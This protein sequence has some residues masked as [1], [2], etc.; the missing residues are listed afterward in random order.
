MTNRQIRITMLYDK[1]GPTGKDIV[2]L[3]SSLI[4]I[5]LFIML[6]NASMRGF[7]RAVRIGEFEGE[8]ALRIPTSPPR[9]MVIIG[10]AFVVLQFLVNAGKSVYSIVNRI[11]GRMQA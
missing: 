7:L 10:S 6:I 5:V 8:G 1:M 4:G 9:A 2:D 3:L 11:R